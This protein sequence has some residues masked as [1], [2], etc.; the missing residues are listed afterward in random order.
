VA[1]PM[2]QSI[3]SNQT[4]TKRLLADATRIFRRATAAMAAA[5]VR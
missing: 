4:T 5:G 3:K 1:T 2:N